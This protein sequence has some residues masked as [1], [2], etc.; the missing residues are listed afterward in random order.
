MKKYIT[1]QL[2]F[3]TQRCTSLSVTIGRRAVVY[4]ADDEWKIRDIVSFFFKMK[5]MRFGIITKLIQ[6]DNFKN[7]TENDH[8]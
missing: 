5:D 4:Y 1:S 3:A 7:D 8:A 6:E 2:L